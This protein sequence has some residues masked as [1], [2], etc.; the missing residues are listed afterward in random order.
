MT[1]TENESSV[2]KFEFTIRAA[3]FYRIIGN[4]QTVVLNQGK[5]GTLLEQ[6]M[7]DISQTPSPAL[8]ALGVMVLEMNVGGALA[9]FPVCDVDVLAEMIHYIIRFY[10]N[11]PEFAD[12]I[13]IMCEIAILGDGLGCPLSTAPRSARLREIAELNNEFRRISN[14]MGDSL[15]VSTEFI[16]MRTTGFHPESQFLRTVVNVK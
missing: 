4:A 9:V 6:L 11:N 16:T 10:K 2:N 13:A 5:N 1:D 15:E 3:A 14:A 7:K 12:K 8:D